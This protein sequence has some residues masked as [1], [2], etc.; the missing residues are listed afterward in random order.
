MKLTIDAQVDT[1]EDKLTSFVAFK[2]I[3]GVFF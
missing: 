3:G 1:H 2:I